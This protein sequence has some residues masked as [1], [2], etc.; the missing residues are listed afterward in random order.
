LIFIEY[1]ELDYKLK[2]F[3]DDDKTNKFFN[4]KLVSLHKPDKDLNVDYISKI[5]KDKENYVL[6]YLNDNFVLQNYKHT[7]LLIELLLI[8]N[9]SLT[10]NIVHLLYLNFSGQKRFLVGLNQTEVVTKRNVNLYNNYVKIYDAFRVLK[11]KIESLHEVGREEQNSKKEFFEEIDLHMDEL[12]EDLYPLLDDDD[13][14]KFQREDPTNENQIYDKHRF[15]T[16]KG[17]DKQSL[18]KNLQMFE[19]SLTL[20]YTLVESKKVEYLSKFIY[21][22]LFYCFKN[23]ENQ[24]VM[25]THPEFLKKLFEIEVEDLQPLLLRLI[26]EIFKNNYSLLVKLPQKEPNIMKLLTEKFFNVLKTK[27]R[28]RELKEKKMIFLISCLRIFPTFFQIRTNFL[29]QNQ[30]AFAK[31]FQQ[32]ASED[33][34]GNILH[35]EL[36]FNLSRFLTNDNFKSHIEDDDPYTVNVPIEVSFSIYFLMTFAVMVAGPNSSNSQACASNKY[37]LSIPE[38]QELLELSTD[39]KGADWINLKLALL[40]YFNHVYVRNRKLEANEVSDLYNI[41]RNLMF[42]ELNAYNRF[43]RNRHLYSRDPKQKFAYE[44]PSNYKIET[45][46]TFCNLIDDL[47]HQYIIYGALD[48]YRFYAER[49]KQDIMEKDH[50]LLDDYVSSQLPEIREYWNN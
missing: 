46:F 38:I 25:S 47:Y 22:Y 39:T 8:N 19:I 32:K 43:V 2:D 1:Y 20:F 10:C 16:V 9:L 45:E 41:M 21:F 30:I 17:K 5:K 29:T 40:T 49:M 31:E 48:S 24:E 28:L 34:L 50:Q 18:L 36:Y 6:K 42:D 26:S 33:D 3:F 12:L 14:E 44:L 27:P 7:L 13:I 37:Y 23:Q 35:T 11:I 4:E 15:D